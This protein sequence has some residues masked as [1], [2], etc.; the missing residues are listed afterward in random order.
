MVGV[1]VGVG[2]DE[3]FV[4]GDGV[5]TWTVLMKGEENTEREEVKARP[6]TMRY[7]PSIHI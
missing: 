6:N 7:T 5:E 3:N 4:G 2:S 1:V